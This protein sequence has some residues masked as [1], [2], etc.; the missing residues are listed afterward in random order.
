MCALADSGRS[1]GIRDGSKGGREHQ[2]WRSRCAN[3]AG[4]W[5]AGAV[6]ITRYSR[7]SQDRKAAPAPI[8]LGSAITSSDPCLP[9]LLPLS[10]FV[11]FTLWPPEHQRRRRFVA[12]LC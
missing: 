1:A 4:E 3:A 5:E 9:G 11:L 7:M 12:L 8:G 2:E 10:S 6:F